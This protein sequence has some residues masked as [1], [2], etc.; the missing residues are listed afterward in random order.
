MNTLPQP[1]K[2]IWAAGL[3]PAISIALFVAALAVSALQER[4]A[5]SAGFQ[6]RAPAPGD[7]TSNWQRDQNIDLA[8][9]L[10]ANQVQS[11]NEMAYRPHRT[12]YGEFLLYCSDDNG[13]HWTAWRVWTGAQRVSGPY[14][15]DP[16]VPAPQ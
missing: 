6:A 1:A 8:R 2:P 7:Y 3:L 15:P 12:M 10:M 14:A 4:P 11:C 9:T 16:L 5:D 13:R